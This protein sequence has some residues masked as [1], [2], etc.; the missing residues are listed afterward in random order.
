MSDNIAICVLAILFEI[1]WNIKVFNLVYHPISNW[2][3]V[4]YIN[5]N[6]ATVANVVEL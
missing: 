5:G 1:Y 6:N 2:E 4:E 3:C